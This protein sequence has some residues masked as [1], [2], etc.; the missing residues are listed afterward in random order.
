M[1]LACLGQLGHRSGLPRTRR[2]LAAIAILA[3]ILVLALVIAASA[4]DSQ[5][6]TRGGL[7]VR[8]ALGP[9]SG[10][11]VGGQAHGPGSGC[12]TDQGSKNPKGG[13]H[14]WRDFAKNA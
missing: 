14:T 3:L 10:G 5:V 2:R 7:I 9:V 1:A 12:K 6:R 4:R 13:R 8:F 11:K